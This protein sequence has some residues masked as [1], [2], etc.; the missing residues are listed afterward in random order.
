MKLKQVFICLSYVSVIFLLACHAY[1]KENLAEMY[2]IALNAIMKEDEALED[3]MEF[4]AID[5][6][7]FD[8]LDR[9]EKD[10]ILQFFEEKYKKNVMDATFEELEEQGLYDHETM[11]LDGILLEIDEIEFKYKT[12]FIEGS[13][14]RSGVGAVGV[15]VIVH[16]EDDKWKV[17]ESKM[18]W[19]S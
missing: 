3:G 8:E 19:V 17:K 6:S 7:H 13:K 1:D 10:R 2:C 16:Q 9:E 14:Y 18:T 4:I 11:S 15:E 12:I 5:M